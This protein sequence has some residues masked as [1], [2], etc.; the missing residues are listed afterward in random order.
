MGFFRGF[1]APFRGAYFV[2]RERLWAHLVAPIIVNLALGGTTLFVVQR[3]MK[4][5]LD[6]PFANSPIMEAIPSISG[7]SL[8]YTAAI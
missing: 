1:L 3:F 5:E 8:L 7:F 2:A 4:Q 6:A